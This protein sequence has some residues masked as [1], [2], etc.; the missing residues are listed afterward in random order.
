[1]LSRRHQGPKCYSP[2]LSGTQ[3]SSWVESLTF[4]CQGLLMFLPPLCLI[5]LGSPS[6][7]QPYQHC[8]A[9]LVAH[10]RYF[11]REETILVLAR[12]S[13]AFSE[14]NIGLE[15]LPGEEELVTQMVSECM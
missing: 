8:L 13:Q 12:T 6:A 15:L 10:T 4:S 2:A 14:L 5:P 11:S 7:P 3:G 9:L 1:M